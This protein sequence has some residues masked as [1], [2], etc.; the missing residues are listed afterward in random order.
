[1]SSRSLAYVSFDRFPAPKGAAV[2]IDAFVSGLASRFDD[3]DL[4]TVASTLKPPTGSI[5]QRGEHSFRHTELPASGSSLVER[6]L[7]FR[8]HLRSWWGRR[9]YDVAH[10]RSI[11][12][13]YPIAREKLRRCDKL[14]F[15]VNGLPSIELK[16]HYPN[17]ADDRELMRKLI[18]Q[19]ETCLELA[20]LIVT[21]SQVNAAYLRERGADPR[22]IRVIPNGVNLDL[23][24]YR[25]PRAWDDRPISLLYSGT[26]AS[27]QGTRTAIK[28]LAL[29]HQNF[30]VK[31]TII[32]SGRPD[33]IQGLRDFAMRLGVGDLLNILDP[34]G[35][36]ELA[37]FHQSADVI[38]VPLQ[39]NDRNVVQGC[40]P[41]KL[42]EALACG[43]PVIASDLPVVTG[44]ARHH[45]EAILVRP[46]SAKA[47][48][49]AV[50][51]LREQPDLRLKLSSQGRERIEEEFTWGR[52]Q[53]QLLAAYE[54]LL[55]SHHNSA[56]S[57][58]STAVSRSNENF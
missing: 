23:F 56:N 31:L 18:A 10:V 50:C 46:G 14:V 13:G 16:Y 37:R 41:L 9:R 28:S 47:I 1:M 34:V 12:E 2:H 45:Q 33:Q 58:S 39:P 19:E 24:S 3:V 7:C 30:P 49:D 52:A 26:L 15:E 42:L 17:V 25:S 20:D 54:V 21:V 27:W 43:T 5:I 48:K 22:K 35:Q 40:C 57:S 38:L 53:Q 4:V 29:C 51:Q 6:V 32:G 8:T 36:E 11:Y 44:I 55:A